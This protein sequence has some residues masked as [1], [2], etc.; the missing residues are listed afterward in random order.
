MGATEESVKADLVALEVVREEK[1]PL[2]QSDVADHEV[3][4]DME[5]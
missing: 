3:Y 4:L 5:W 2:V 1:L